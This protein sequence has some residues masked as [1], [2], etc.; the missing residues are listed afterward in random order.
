MRKC[1]YTLDWKKFSWIK[2][3]TQMPW[4]EQQQQPLRNRTTATFHLV[5]HDAY[6]AAVKILWWPMFH[7]FQSHKL[8][9]FNSSNSVSVQ[10]A[11]H[12]ASEEGGETENVSQTNLMTKTFSKNEPMTS[13]A[14]SPRLVKTGPEVSH[15]C[16]F[17]PSHMSSV[18]PVTLVESCSLLPCH[19]FYIGPLK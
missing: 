17:F 3:R 2:F 19:S 15:T 14:W 1:F 13:T 6:R 11:I 9:F 5:Q 8:H 12:Y 16:C 4:T 7:I 10:Y 18:V